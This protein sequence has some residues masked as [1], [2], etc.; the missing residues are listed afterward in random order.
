M[1]ASYDIETALVT[2]AG[3]LTFINI[4]QT[5]PDFQYALLEKLS[6]STPNV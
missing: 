3:F 6:K 4:C 2:G 5:Q 1:E